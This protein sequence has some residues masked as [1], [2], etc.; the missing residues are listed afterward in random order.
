MTASIHMKFTYSVLS[1]SQCFFYGGNNEGRSWLAL[2]PMSVTVKLTTFLGLS[3]EEEHLYV[4]TNL[5]YNVPF[6]E[7]QD[8]RGREVDIYQLYM[9]IYLL[10]YC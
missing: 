9:W 5:L 3:L 1:R 10:I 7:K 2:K 6:F 8:G 4:F